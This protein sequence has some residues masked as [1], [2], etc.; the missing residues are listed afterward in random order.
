MYTYVTV[1]VQ[2]PILLSFP[3]VKN[4]GKPTWRRLVEA[5]EDPAGGN[6]RALAQKITRDHP[7]EPGNHTHQFVKPYMKDLV[8]CTL[9]FA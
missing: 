4:S 3:K 7:G 9:C 8:I 2:C 1:S 5:V 6:N